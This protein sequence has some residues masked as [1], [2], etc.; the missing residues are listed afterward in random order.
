MSH[1]D[2]QTKHQ[3]IFDCLVFSFIMINFF[4]YVKSAEG[5]KAILNYVQAIV[6]QDTVN[7]DA[8][9]EN[10]FTSDI[11]DAVSSGAST[12]F[13]FLIRV[14]KNRRLWFD[15]NIQEYEIYHTVT[16]DV[17]KKE[18]LVTISYPDGS[19]GN[20]STTEWE[21]MSQWMSE[22]KSV[23]I[24]LPGIK[25]RDADYHLSLRAEMKCIR[26]PFPL[27]YLLAFVTLLNF[28][29]PW[30]NVPL[31]LNPVHS[32]TATIIEGPP[33]HEERSQ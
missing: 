32:E 7:L 20:Q 27:N 18:Y 19:V 4:L 6:N 3:Y 22:L 14:K 10:A 11:V 17:L 2:F 12:R 5:A 29:T 16:Y 31:N 24:P 30:V 23:A 26:I 25:N 9:L 28:D 21:E 13:R 33:M 15:K 8:V 1:M